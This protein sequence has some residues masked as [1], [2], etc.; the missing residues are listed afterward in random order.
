MTVDGGAKQGHTCDGD[1]ILLTSADCRQTLAQEKAE[2]PLSKQ[3]SF[4]IHNLMYIHDN[5]SIGQKVVIGIYCPTM[6]SVVFL[7]ARLF[8]LRV[9]DTCA[10]YVR[11]PVHALHHSYQLS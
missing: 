8:S 3:V 9:V 10:A 7:F 4:M 2:T 5:H 11:P 1:T 6:P